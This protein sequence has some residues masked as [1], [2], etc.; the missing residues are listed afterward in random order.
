MVERLDFGDG[1]LRGTAAFLCRPARSARGATHAFCRGAPAAAYR[2]CA[3]GEG[4]WAA[5]RPL[6]PRRRRSPRVAVDLGELLL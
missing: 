6:P 3:D 5:C 4:K 2:P 1:A